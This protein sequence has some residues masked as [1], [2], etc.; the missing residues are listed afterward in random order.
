MEPKNEDLTRTTF[1]GPRMRAVENVTATP[2][3]ARGALGR[4]LTQSKGNAKTQSFR[5]DS[6][7]F[8]GRGEGDSLLHPRNEIS[9]AMNIVEFS[10][11]LSSSW[12]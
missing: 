3:S 7:C 2:L 6:S 8:S 10:P 12:K 5:V 9:E 4:E 11:R 1:L